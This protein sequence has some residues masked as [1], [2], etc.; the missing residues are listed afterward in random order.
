[1]VCQQLTLRRRVHGEVYLPE[2]IWERA[3]AHKRL[4]DRARERGWLGAA[5]RVAGDLSYELGYLRS[6]IDRVISV[7][8]RQ[9]ELL[10][11]PC[12]ADVFREILSL[13][14]EF[15]EVRLDLK[16]GMF[17]L[18]RGG[19][20]YARLRFSVGPGGEIELPVSVD[21]SHPF[22]ASDWG[23]WQQQYDESVHVLQPPPLTGRLDAWQE[24]SWHDRWPE[25]LPMM[26]EPLEA[27][28]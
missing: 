23:A 24:E 6:Q 8:D 18:A 27:P 10:P 1:M 15:P 12:Q 26:D 22:T 17:I 2:H 9:T 11:I 3:T 16:L 20:T 5:K 4:V 7:L 14:H 28:F 25:N 13:P 19:Q 21:Y